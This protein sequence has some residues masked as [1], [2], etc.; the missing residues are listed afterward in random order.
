MLEFLMKTDLLFEITM[1]I[2]LLISKIN[3]KV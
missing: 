1:F 3:E 2:Y